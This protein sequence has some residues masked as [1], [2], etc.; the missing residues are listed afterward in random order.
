MTI[1]KIT[2][3]FILLIIIS[4]CSGVPISSIVQLSR[5]DPLTTDPQQI[6]IG[7]VA[8]QSLHFDDHAAHLSFGYAT[9]NPDL[10]VGV[11]L[12][13]KRS[14]LH[15]TRALTQPL[16]PEQRFSIF[17]LD[18]IQSKIMRRAQAEILRLKEKEVDGEGYLS[19]NVTMACFDRPAP[20]E[21]IADIYMQ[22]AKGGD[23][24][25]LQPEVDLIEIAKSAGVYDQWKACHLE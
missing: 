4:G 23:F 12:P 25:L 11:Q 13:V 18:P 5:L 3:P 24:V 15:D 6:R 20:I 8:D 17:Y 16:K 19:V 10:S 2:F 7:L 21:L 1:R 22:F 14:V 9:Q